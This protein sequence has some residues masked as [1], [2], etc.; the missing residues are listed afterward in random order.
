VHKSRK[1]NE[2]FAK[3]KWHAPSYAAKTESE[4]S[5]SP[6]GDRNLKIK[7]YIGIG[8]KVP[9]AP[10]RFDFELPIIKTTNIFVEI[11][12]CT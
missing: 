2:Y 11:R 4:V 12:S 8:L 5:V 1:V 10:K 7:Q 3:V 6:C 9:C